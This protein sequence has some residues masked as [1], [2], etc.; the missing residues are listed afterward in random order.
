MELDY[1]ETSA[2]DHMD[3]VHAGDTAPKDCCHKVQDLSWSGSWQVNI[4]QD[5]VLRAAVVWHALPCLKT[6][7]KLHCFILWLEIMWIQNFYFVDNTEV[8]MHFTGTN[9]C[10]Y[11]NV[12]PGLWW[13]WCGPGTPWCFP[14][15]GTG[16]SHRSGCRNCWQMNQMVEFG[17]LQTIQT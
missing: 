9:Y 17:C 11:I 12:W 5:G 14:D 13:I 8:K 1:R 15:P 10:M 7:G 3:F 16:L 4:R 6:K 2:A